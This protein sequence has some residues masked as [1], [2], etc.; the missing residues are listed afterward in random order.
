M[1][2]Q[3]QRL[4]KKVLALH[5]KYGTAMTITRKVAGTYDPSASSAAETTQTFSTTGII[6]AYGTSL[7]RADLDLKDGNKQLLRAV[8]LPGNVEP[9]LGDTIG[10]IDGATWEVTGIIPQELDGDYIQFQIKV[11]R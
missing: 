1:S 9:K 7:Y 10:P 5:A 3:S 2:S 11:A 4:A 8:S 6:Q